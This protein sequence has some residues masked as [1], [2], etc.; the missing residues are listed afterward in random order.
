MD[1]NIH[2]INLQTLV[3]GYAASLVHVLDWDNRVSLTMLDIN[4]VNDFA[5]YLEEKFGKDFIQ[6]LTFRDVKKLIG[7]F[8]TLQDNRDVE[9]R[10]R[11]YHHTAKYVEL[12]TRDMEKFEKWLKEKF[13][14]AGMT[15]TS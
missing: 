8:L 1:E 7:G 2:E 15:K 6:D 11:I 14:Q 3:E 5:F 12:E 9:V 10:D 13:Q 4:D